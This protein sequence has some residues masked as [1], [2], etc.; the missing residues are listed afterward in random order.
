ME[1][2]TSLSNGPL[3]SLARHPL[4]LPCLCL[5]S[6]LASN[7]LVV[8][9]DTLRVVLVVFLLRHR[10]SHDL[11]DVFVLQSMR[12]AHSLRLVLHAP[13]PDQRVVERGE[14]F[15]GDG[16]HRATH[17]ETPP[18]G[19]E[20]DGFLEVRLLPLGFCEDAY[21]AE[22]PPDLGHE[23]V[24][25]EAHVHADDD[26][27][28]LAGEPVH[29]LDGDHV[30][31]VV[32]VQARH[33]LAVALNDVDNLVDG[34]VLAAKHLAVVHLVLVE[35]ALHRALRVVAEPGERHRRVEP[36]TTRRPLRDD[37]VR[38]L[39]IQPDAHGFQLPL[40]DGAVVVHLLAPAVKHHQHHVSGARH[41]DDLAATAAAVR[42]AFDD[43]GQIQHLDAA[44][45]IGDVA[46]DA[47]E[48]RKLVGSRLRLRARQ[49][50]K[51]R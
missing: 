23:A 20:H 14:K 45:L 17:A 6:A 47:C 7:V 32:A 1:V 36:D 8:L 41:G 46:G 44:I 28:V 37:D 13:A 39:L 48:R 5:L 16:L 33:V 25:V 38:W 34:D 26:A 22:I 42:G 15:V 11:Q 2:C 31:L 43:T 51:Q 35:D 27:V 40:Q 9:L 50:R 4:L 24:E 18:A 30:Y 19:R 29:V 21:E 12:L 10:L 3:G 49:R